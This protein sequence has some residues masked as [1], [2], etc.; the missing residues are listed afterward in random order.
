MTSDDETFLQ[1]MQLLPTFSPTC[2]SCAGSDEHDKILDW[3]RAYCECKI[4]E[5]PNSLA[6]L[7][8]QAQVG[9]R[10]RE[11][12]E[13]GNSHATSL[14]V[15]LVAMACELGCGTV[16]HHVISEPALADRLLSLPDDPSLQVGALRW[17]TASI[18][19]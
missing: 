16:V 3:L 2:S 4:Q 18:V 7:M 15:Q 11:A 8:G 13:A 1:L 19:R 17:L 12:M 5:D 9:E 14:L 6:A 10:L